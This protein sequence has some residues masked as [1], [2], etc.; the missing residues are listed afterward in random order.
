MSKEEQQLSPYKNRM[1]HE[2]S[3]FAAP[4]PAQ[5]TVTGKCANDFEQ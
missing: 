5:A 2:Q 1:N 3:F 4:A